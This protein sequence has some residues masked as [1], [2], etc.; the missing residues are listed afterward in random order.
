MKKYL[1]TGFSGFVSMHFL[2]YLDSLLCPVKVLGVDVNEPEN[3]PVY[4]FVEY[5]FLKL[6]LLDKE[7]VAKMLSSFQP[8]FILH[9]ASYSSVAY[10]WKNPVD[11]FV[12]N[13][14]IFLNLVD[15]VRLLGIKCR[16]LS[17]GSSEEYGKITD[18]EIPIKESA[19]TKPES[20]YA[21]AR[22]AQEMLSEIYANHYKVDIILTRSFNHIGPVQK[23]IF[24]I[25]SFAK[26]LTDIKKNI[27]NST[28]INVGNISLTRDFVDVRD[29]VKAYYLLLQ[30]GKTGQVYNICSGKGYTL[31]L[32][33]KTMMDIIKINPPI[34]VD[35]GLIRPGENKT[36]IG[37]NHKI[38]IETGWQP[39][40]SLN[41][42]LKDIVDYWMK[43]K[44]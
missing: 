13:S 4:E 20:P 36:I 38:F 26:K 31:E 43:K 3:N 2:D 1:I 33:L 9:L 14:N 8:D 35:A 42:S 21:V 41:D 18:A 10:S 39:L 11:A 22:V 5:N 34:I 32:V 28:E 15:Q 19:R 40:I 6:N 23:D 37:S 16:I 29:V 7:D 25:S 30:K 12:N 24:V 44:Q 17:I 27:A